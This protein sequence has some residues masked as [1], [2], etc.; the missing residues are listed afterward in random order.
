M[1][2]ALVSKGIQVTVVTT[3]NGLEGKDINLNQW[4]DKDYGKIIYI[5]TAIHYLPIKLLVISF[6]QLP[7]TQLVHLTSIFYPASLLMALAALTMGKKIVWSARGELYPSALVYSTPIKK[8][9]LS[10]VRLLR[11][12]ITFHSTCPRETEYIY[13]QIGSDVKITEIPNFI[14]LPDKVN[15]NESQKYFLYLGR[16]HPIKSIHKLLEALMKSD[17]F[18]QSEYKLL[19]AGDDSTTYAAELK[20]KIDGS[21]IKDK[22]EFRGYVNNPKEKQK[23]CAN[24]H[25]LIL[26]SESENFGNVVLESLAQGTPVI[27]SKGTP[28]KVLSKESAGFWVDNKPEELRKII[29]EVLSLKPEVY[30]SYRRQ[31]LKLAEERFDIDKNVNQWIQLYKQSLTK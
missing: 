22:I 2:R 27:A 11:K 7:K 3:N 15:R 8:M 6:A 30:Q 9:I 29:N 24:A 18:I 19:I 14:E 25:F 31:A 1:T 17:Q 10:I 5:K 12:K 20:E 26:P 13:Q 21:V 16:I 28:W 4:M 23:L